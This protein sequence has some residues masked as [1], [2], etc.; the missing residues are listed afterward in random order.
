M[1]NQGF[2]QAA[3]PFSS[4]P[5][6]WQKHTMAWRREKKGRE[7]GGGEEERGGGQDPRGETLIA[8]VMR[9]DQIEVSLS[10]GALLI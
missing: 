8:K 10:I 9:L 4:S 3:L 6:C 7:T 2:V 1:A 5:P